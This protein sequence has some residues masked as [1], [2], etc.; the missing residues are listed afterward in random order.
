ME[1]VKR[2][3][4]RKGSG[5]V[6]RPKF[7]TADGRERLG[8]YRAKFS[9][10]D[11]VGAEH[12]FDEKVPGQQVNKQ[13]AGEYL[14]TKMA[15]AKRGELL[16]GTEAEK[17]SY[18]GM[19]EALIQEYK[20][21]HRKSLHVAK[22]RKTLY[23]WNLNHLDHFFAGHKALAIRPALIQKFKDKR[24]AEGAGNCSVNRSL[25]LL[26]RM[27]YLAVDTERFPGDR[28]PKIKLLQ[29]PPPRKGFLEYAQFVSLRQALPEHLRPVATLGFFTGMRRGEIMKLR[30]ENVN[31]D[32]GLIRLDPGST[33]ND[34]SRVIPLIG[35]LPEMLRILREKSPASEHVFTRNGVRMQTFRKAW[36][37]A[38]VVA[39][40]GMMKPRLDKTTGQPILRNKKPV[41]KY[42]GRTFHDLRRCG[43]SN[44]L[45][46]GV[47][48]YTARRISGHKTESV[49]QRYNIT[50][51]RHLKEAGRKLEEYFNRDKSK[52]SESEP[53]EHAESIPENRVLH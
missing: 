22:D 37:S 13:V 2:R 21:N 8:S 4:N 41:L 50:I 36:N 15:E 40:L 16:T 39:G 46:A 35:E 42:E 20:D 24:L 47:D 43:V 7:K 38:C 52:T 49:F 5:C 27:F 25:Q 3:R 1:E 14:K 17:L 19:R 23:I 6:Y 26:R 29:E 45:Q 44:L 48:P 11:N 51:E 31:L 9:W 32:K 30:W 33:K 28:V 18:E 12:H 10:T 34:E 53:A